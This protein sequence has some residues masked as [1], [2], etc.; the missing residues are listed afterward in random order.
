MGIIIT[1]LFL[2]SISIVL[3]IGFRVFIRGNRIYD[4]VYSEENKI[5][6]KKLAEIQRE[7][8]KAVNENR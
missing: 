8:Y 6:N 1:V 3:F 4:D 2:I 7:M 5:F